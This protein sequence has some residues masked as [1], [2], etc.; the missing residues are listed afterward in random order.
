M[1]LWFVGDCAVLIVGE[2]N[3][4]FLRGVGGDAA[5]EPQNTGCSGYPEEEFSGT[6]NQAVGRVFKQCARI[7][8]ASEILVRDSR[9]TK[10]SINSETDSVAPR[11]FRAGGRNGILR[12]TSNCCPAGTAD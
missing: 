4:V 12:Q 8:E 6:H 1:S 11:R 5:T 3:A 10:R 9:V 2:S 7:I